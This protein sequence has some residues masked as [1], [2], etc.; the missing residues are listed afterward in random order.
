MTDMILRRSLCE[1]RAVCAKSRVQVDMASDTWSDVLC[2][3]CKFD[4]ALIAVQWQIKTLREV[5]GDSRRD[6][7]CGA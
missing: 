6:R 4:D 7:L 3:L 5:L 2:C 1:R